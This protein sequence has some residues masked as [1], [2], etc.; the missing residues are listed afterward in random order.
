MRIQDWNKRPPPYELF[1]EPLE[2]S[3]GPMDC[4]RIK[5]AYILSKYGHA[6]QV[7]EDGTR[8]F[9]HPKA[10]AWI[11]IDEL[12]GRDPRTIIDHLLHDL[13][14]DT[15]LLSSYRASL[16]FGEDVALDVRGLTKLPKGKE[17]TSDYLARVIARGPRAILTKLDDRLH[18]LRC[19]GDCSQ[20]KRTR[21]IVE[22]EE[23]HLPL[24]V[25]ALEVCGDPWKGYANLVQGKMM[26]AITFH[27]KT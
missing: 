22:T 15:Y 23:F 21:Q 20:D 25:P 19:L 6:K 26:E 1:F 9:D 8:Y 5:F 16:N 10:A 12:K 14:E 18:N 2:V 11:Y 13:R 17:K 27:R 7:R 3:L 24:L 4:E